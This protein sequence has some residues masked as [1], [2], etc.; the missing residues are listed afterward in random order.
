MII[1]R[2]KTLL[3]IVRGTMFV[4]RFELEKICWRAAI[5][6]DQFARLLTKWITNDTFN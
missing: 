1:D 3:K 2:I 4:A 5:R 6:H